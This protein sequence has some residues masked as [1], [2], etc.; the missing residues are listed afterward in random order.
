MIDMA[1][2]IKD[3]VTKKTHR[4]LFGANVP[5]PGA[6]EVNFLRVYDLEANDI[7]HLM[8]N[9]MGQI[10]KHPAANILTQTMP[11]KDRIDL[12]KEMK[13][14]LIASTF[15]FKIVSYKPAN[16]PSYTQQKNFFFQMRFFTF[17]PIR[18]E[19]VELYQSFNDEDPLDEVKAGE[20][21]FLK[22][23]REN[24]RTSRNAGEQVL[25]NIIFIEK[26]IDPSI[27]KI[28]SENMDF[29]EY[30]KE[31]Y[32]TIDMF[33]SKTHFFFGSA[34]IPLFEMLR[35]QA[36][37]ITRAKEVE[38]YNDKLG[39]E[40]GSLV[41]IMTNTGKSPAV[42]DTD[43]SSDAESTKSGK[44]PSQGKNASRIIYSEPMS[45]DLI[46]KA[47]SKIHNRVDGGQMSPDKRVYDHSTAILNQMSQ[48][49]IDHTVDNPDLRKKLR[50]ERIRK[51]AILSGSSQ[52]G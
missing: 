9:G 48:Q 7:R 18:T 11:S 40:M 41:V 8:E 17:E 27:S 13:D 3:Q 44:Q 15:E 51:M 46:E 22:K 26:T 34:K 33:D 4:N 50:I 14:P 6:K 38:I 28:R 37:T 49:E 5:L 25:E 32:V 39:M 12:T 35:Q 19:Q 2:Q 23:V 21:Y 43:M 20:N 45:I 16:T 24:H 31:R 36:P 29:A 30:L 47:K 10:L 1:H 52:A 42:R